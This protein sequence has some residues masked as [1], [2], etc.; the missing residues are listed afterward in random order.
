MRTITARKEVRELS[1]ARLRMKL[2]PGDMLRTMRE[3]QELTQGELST[4]SGVSQPA[5][6]A[7]ENGTEALGVDRARR[8]AKALSVHPA[9]LLFPDWEPEP[10]ESER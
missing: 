3:L 5:I 2:S 8:L 10:N 9:V 6:S 7:I 4:A 1:P